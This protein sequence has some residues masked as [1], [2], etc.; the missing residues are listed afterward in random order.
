M[1]LMSARVRDF[2]RFTDLTITDIPAKMRLAVLV[3]PNGSGKTS[4]FEAFNYWMSPFRGVPYQKAY[5][6]KVGTVADDNWDLVHQKIQLRFH[7]ADIN[8]RQRTDRVR[9]AFYF[10]SAYRHEADFDFQQIGRAGDALE[11]QKR[12]QTLISAESRV[13]DNYQ[14][15]VASTIAELFDDANADVPAGQLR[16]KLVGRV[17]DS[18]LRV[19]GDL[20]LTG[21]GKPMVDG[22]FLFAKGRSENFRF[23]NLS[24]GEKAAFDLL[25]DFVVKTEFFDDTIYCIDEPELHIHPRLQASLLDEL[26][27]TLPS[28]CQLWLATHSVG[29]T[30][31]AMQLHRLN[32]GEVVFLD[33]ENQDYDQAV[34]LKPAQVTRELWKR[35]F[36]V[37]LDDLADLLAPAQLVF[38]E[39]RSLGAE[40]TRSTTFDAEIYRRIFGSEYPDTEF[41][42]LG[43]TSE[44]ERNGLL[45]KTVFKR[46]FAHMRMW[47]IIDRDDRSGE[48]IA[49]LATQGI[50]VLLKRDIES[51]L[52]DEEIIR[53]LA[54]ANGK[55][56]SAEGLIALK[57]AL[58]EE[59]KVRGG[60]SDDVK[61]IAGP[62]YVAAKK[63]LGL[64]QCGNTAEEFAKV[65]LSPLITSDT[66]TYRDLRLAVFGAHAEQG[67]PLLQ[68]SEVKSVRRRQL[69]D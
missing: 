62:L 8:P 24:G 51:Y 47:S 53:R 1:R 65:S 25:L 4:L 37:A 46:L 11:D 49:Q 7:D 69:Q 31:R 56:G 67:V 17:R 9:K 21:L 16:D 12:P 40:G 29:M 38:C 61:A 35:V 50:R 2:K 52:W 15:L 63:T 45:L 36:T 43:G 3:G 27:R 5:H 68:G 18:M 58:L 30:R 42:P 10:R 33:F 22:T 34:T 55:P 23:M 41:I 28:N 66:T 32:P 57:A 14:R 48:E 6:V 39:G 60:P 59:G 20:L 19:F 54:E 26:Y 44:V 64:T 13:S